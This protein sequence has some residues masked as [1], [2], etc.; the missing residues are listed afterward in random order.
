M[1]DDKNAVGIVKQMRHNYIC[2]FV[3]T[4]KLSCVSC[5][6]NLKEK[7]SEYCMIHVICRKWIFVAFFS[8]PWYNGLSW[9]KSYLGNYRC[10]GLSINVEIFKGY[11]SQQPNNTL[12]VLH[13][14]AS[15]LMQSVKRMCVWLREEKD[16]KSDMLMN[17]LWIR[18]LRRTVR[19][20][21]H[22]N[23]RAKWITRLMTTAF[24]QHR[25]L[26]ENRSLPASNR[27]LW[28]W[29]ARLLLLLSTSMTIK[30]DP[31]WLE[32]Y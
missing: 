13:L 29:V 4:L 28:A 11:Y 21:F 26:H 10:P 17:S 22:W 15:I 16:I 1:E 8:L 3:T 2:K 18:R 30:Q 25:K 9:R 23:I 32:R 14:Y 19:G 6:Q 27:S 12:H 7:V 20:C 31:S 5:Y 24:W